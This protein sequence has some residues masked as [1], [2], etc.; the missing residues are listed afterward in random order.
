[1]TVPMAL[2]DFVPV[3][4][5]LASVILLQRRLY[6]QMKSGVF[7]LFACGA[8]MV[9]TAG[10]LKAL[11]KLL[12]A[13][14]LCDF[15]ALNLTFMPLQSVGFLVTGV[16]LLLLLL[17]T[18]QKTAA[19]APAVYSGTML[20]VGLMVAGVLLTDVCLAILAKRAKKPLAA[21]LFLVSF[22]FMMG[23]GYLSSRDFA[24][25]SMHWIA[26]SVN[27]VGQGLLLAG[28]LLLGQTDGKEKTV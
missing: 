4:L 9:F 1:M 27:A 19:A 10:F 26:Q 2:M 6:P 21:V 20:F 24:E 3:F 18:R 11:W 12:Y 16:S 17:G 15:E 13:L 14:N 5:F 23:M 22:V 7:A 8:G 28:T 25:A